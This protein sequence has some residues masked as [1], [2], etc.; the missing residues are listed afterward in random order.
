MRGAGVRSHKITIVLIVILVSMLVLSTTVPADA[1]DDWQKGDEANYTGGHTF[2]EEFWKADY[3]NT[4]KEGYNLT[5]SLFYMNKDNVQAFLVAIN[6]IKNETNVGTLPYQLFG[7]HYYSPQGQEV[8][9]GAIF[10]F[11]MGYNDTNNPE[12]GVPEPEKEDTFFIIPFGAGNLVTG[13]YIPTVD[14]SMEK[15]DNSHYNFKISY[16]NMYA[17]VTNNPFWGALL[18][19]GWI[20]QFT[21][22]TMEYRITLDKE[23]GVVKAETYYTLGQVMELWAVL[24]G[25]PV[26]VDVTQIPKTL[27]I[28]AVHY[29]ATFTSYNRIV[30]AGSGN[31]IKTGITKAADENLTIET[32]DNERVFDIGFR[33]TYDVLDETK[34][35]KETLKK[36]KKAIN[37]LLKARLMDHLL[38]A[39]QLGFSADLMSVMSYGISDNLQERF[40][41][42]RDLKQKALMNFHMNNLWYAVAFPEWG[43]YRIEHDPVY[44]AYTSFDIGATPEEAEKSGPVCGNIM[45]V[46]AAT[47]ASVCVLG[48]KRRLKY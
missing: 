46:I 21:E 9:I 10:A 23:N 25:I 7:L 44:T 43:G 1:M 3:T 37:I 48:F 41:S 32:S 11:L 17:I 5:T 36:D 15:I 24:F 28:A 35:P 40:T 39:H 42:P 33:G 20:A 34:E 6:E 12:Q 45:L 26:Q 18:Q 16:K 19:T 2:E 4:T 31:T 38:V 8:F 30:G 13:K 47:T 29:V 14:S 27:G 22:L